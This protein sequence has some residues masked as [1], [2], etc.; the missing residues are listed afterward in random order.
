MVKIQ[1]SHWMPKKYFAFKSNLVILVC[2]L[3]NKNSKNPLDTNK[4]KISF[5]D[6]FIILLYYK[7]MKISSCHRII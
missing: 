5:K 7:N 2:F 6:N 1:K 3:K 4:I